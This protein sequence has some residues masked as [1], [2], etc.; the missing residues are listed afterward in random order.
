[1][2]DSSLQAYAKAVGANYEQLLNPDHPAAIVVDT[3]QYKDE[4]TN[5]FVQ[6]KAIHAKIGQSLHLSYTNEETNKETELKEVTIAAKTDQLPMGMRSAAVGELDIV[7]SKRVLER[8]IDEK[9]E[10]FGQAQLFLKSKD[11]LKTQQEIEEF[12]DS[13]LSFLNEYQSR[14][15]EEQGI[16]IMSVFTYGFIVLIS[17]ISIANIFNTISTSIS[18]RKREFAMLKSVGMTPKGF[19]KMMNYESIFYGVKSLLFGL[20]LSFV[21]MYFIHRTLSQRY[22]FEFTFSW[23]SILSVIAAVFVIVGSAMLYSSSKVKKENI[24]DALKQENI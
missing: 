1:M 16:L 23:V 11:P 14:V 13:N 18:L 10:A 2:N 6:T 9:I 5:K 22:L 20:P 3:I 24:I 21:V 8:L 7:V 12:S 17:A 19:T 15:M 4:T